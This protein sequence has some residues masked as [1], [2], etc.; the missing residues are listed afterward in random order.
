LPSGAFRRRGVID[1][2]SDAIEF[3]NPDAL[4]RLI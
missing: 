3:R 1:D 2:H 4:R